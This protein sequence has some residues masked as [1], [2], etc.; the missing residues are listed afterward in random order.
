MN[1]EPRAEAEKRVV[2]CSAAATPETSRNALN[3]VFIPKGAIIPNTVAKIPEIVKK[4]PI[5]VITPTAINTNKTTT[6]IAK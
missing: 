5:P 4:D 1:A 2:L 6:N 3:D